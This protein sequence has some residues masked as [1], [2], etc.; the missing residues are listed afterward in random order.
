MSLIKF[1]CEQGRESN[2][3]LVFHATPALIQPIYKKNVDLFFNN[4]IYAIHNY[5]KSS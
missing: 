1:A 3:Q 2:M 5:C 4:K